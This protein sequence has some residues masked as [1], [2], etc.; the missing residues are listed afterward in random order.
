MRWTGCVVFFLSALSACAAP[1]DKQEASDSKKSAEALAPKGLAFRYDYEPSALISRPTRGTSIPSLTPTAAAEPQGVVQRAAMAL[2]LREGFAF[3]KRD[4]AREVSRFRAGTH[5]IEV[6]ERNGVL[7]YTDLAT[8]NR[9]AGSEPPDRSR[10]ID[11]G[12]SLIEQLERQ[13]LLNQ[14][15]ILWDQPVVSHRFRQQGPGGTP[16]EPVQH[17]GTERKMDTRVTYYRAIN[18]IPVSSS[19]IRMT[20]TDRETLAALRMDWRQLEVDSKSS[21]DVRL[22]FEEARTKFETLPDWDHLQAGTYVNVFANELV[23]WDPPPSGLAHSLDPAY[24]FLYV[25]KSPVID[26]RDEFVVSKKLKK[27]MPA[28]GSP[29]KDPVLDADDEPGEPR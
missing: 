29:G 12:K 15:E 7:K 6:G 2:N 19:E 24:Y 9:D 4:P 16:G 25:V 14:Q 10:G 18:G 3:E 20:F 22:S 1:D 23:Y 5:V 8:Y 27:I 28:D 13:G 21:I 17:P 26:G 11:L